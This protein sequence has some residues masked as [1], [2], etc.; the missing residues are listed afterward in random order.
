M[1]CYFGYYCGFRSG[2]LQHGKLNKKLKGLGFDET[3]SKEF[4]NKL[5][6]ERAVNKV[7]EQTLDL[8]MRRMELLIRHALVNMDVSAY[9]ILKGNGEKSEK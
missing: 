2:Y 8:N 5:E 7:M 9:S 1:G 6:E 4:I 3:S